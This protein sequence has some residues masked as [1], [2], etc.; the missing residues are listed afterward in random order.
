MTVPNLFVDV[1][2]LD[3]HQLG[4]LGEGNEVIVECAGVTLGIVDTQR[5]RHSGR[6]RLCATVHGTGAVNNDHGILATSEVLL[7]FPC[8]V[9]ALTLL[10]GEIAA[11]EEGLDQLVGHQGAGVELLCTLGDTVHECSVPIAIISHKGLP[12]LEHGLGGLLGVVKGVVF[13]P[14]VILDDANLGAQGAQRF[15]VLGVVHT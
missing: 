13:F 14:Q 15:A 3:L 1:L 2:P 10:V 9:D 8:S 11:S 7:R 6:D 12:I 4:I 5:Q